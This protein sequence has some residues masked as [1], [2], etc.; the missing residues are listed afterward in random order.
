MGLFDTICGILSNLSE[1]VNN[2]QLQMSDIQQRAYKEAQRDISDKSDNELRK[3]ITSGKS[4]LKDYGLRQAA[5]EEAAK[6][7]ETTKKKKD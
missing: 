1:S 3:I 6:R 2:K 7:K 4:T 5:L